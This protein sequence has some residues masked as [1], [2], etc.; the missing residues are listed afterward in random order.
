MA[1]SVTFV[2][3]VLAAVGLYCVARLVSSK[4]SS[5]PLPPGPK[6]LPLLG[7]LLDMPS[8]REW[9]TFAKWGQQYGVSWSPPFGSSTH[10]GHRRFQERYAL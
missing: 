7:N 6:G 9:H 10:A 4:K 5:L 1:F 8:E 2:D 3:F